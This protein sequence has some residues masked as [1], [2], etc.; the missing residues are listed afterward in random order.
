[1][2]GVERLTDFDRLQVLWNMFFVEDAKNLAWI[3]WDVKR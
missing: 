2:Q 3:V 1:M